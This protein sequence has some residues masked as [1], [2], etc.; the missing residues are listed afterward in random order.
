[1]ILET[2]EDLKKYISI[3]DSFVFEDFKPYV[4]KSVNTFLRKYAGNLHEQLEYQ[5]VG[6]SNAVI[7]NEAREFLRSAISNFGYFLYLPYASVM[8]DSSGI[9]VVNSEQRKNA[10]WWQLKDIR[11]ELLRSGHESMDLLLAILEKHPDIF[12]L[13]HDQF[14]TINNEL[15]VHNAV[16]FS[17]YFNIFES[18]QTYLALQPTIR[19]VE[20]QYIHTML[21]YELVIALKSEVTGNLK[22]LKINLQKAIVAFT[23]AK[24]AEVGLFL[25]DENGLR[26]NFETMVDG[27][28]EGVNYGKSAE[29]VAKLVCEQ[30]NNGTQYL[31]L[32]K[33]IILDNVLDFSEFTNPLIKSATS[34]SGYKPYDTRGLFSM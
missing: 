8:M 13:W 33:Q 7:V 29:Q 12:I 23:V 1:M 15:L 31:L 5:A 16:D 27:R 22:Y 2:T 6:G 20:D 10:E 18:R 11:R 32:A 21:C 25:L 9:S 34:G 19:Q 30:T 24:V 14:S 17:K 4:L 3:S 28:K 26:V